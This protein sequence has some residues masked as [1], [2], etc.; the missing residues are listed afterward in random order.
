MSRLKTAALAS[1]LMATL[2][3]PGRAGDVPLS[4]AQVGAIR[5]LIA[6]FMDSHHAPGATFAIGMNDRIVWTE[7]YGW[8]DIENHVRATPSTA[9]RSAS[10]GKP[11]TATAVMALRERG[12]L[13][14]DAPIQKYCSQFPTKPWPITTRDL[15]SHTSG[16]RAPN[17]GDELYNTRHFG[18]VSDALALFDRDSLTMRPGTDFSYTTWG[19][20]A[21]GCVLEGA[22][23]E[24]Y[25]ALMKRMIFDPAGMTE[26]RQDDPRAIIPN[27]AAG[28]ILE[29]NELKV[30]RWADMSAKLPAGGWVTTASDLV[31][32]MQAWMNGKFVSDSTRKLMLSPYAL[33][34]HGGT[35]DNFGLGWFLDD[36][37]G[38]RAGLHGGGTPQV[39]GIAFFVPEKRLAIAGVFNLE[40]IPGMERIQLAERIADVALGISA[41]DSIAGATS[42]VINRMASPSC[43]H[44]TKANLTADCFEPNP[45]ERRRVGTP[46]PLHPGQ[47]LLADTVAVSYGFVASAASAEVPGVCVNSKLE[48]SGGCV[49]GRPFTEVAYCPECRKARAAWERSRGH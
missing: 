20:V 35:V 18:S 25:R 48:A 8:A 17:D 1:L 29:G 24:D 39:S 19:Y 43:V 30:S 23:G 13:D 7:G 40:N 11:M 3:R 36:Y 9:Y 6:R 34:R 28:Y 12:R 46:C 49:V 4:D 2:A 10:I 37:H 21:L 41:P 47:R 45:D 22:T 42:P 33:P 27:R 5:T 32:F 14:I 16:I 44:A 31:R 38:M 15:L 26:T